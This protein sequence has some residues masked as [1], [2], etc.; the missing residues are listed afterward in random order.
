MKLFSKNTSKKTKRELFMRLAAVLVTGVILEVVAFLS[1]AWFASSGNVNATGMQVSVMDMGSYDLIID[2]TTYYENAEIYPYT[3]LFKSHLSTNEGY[4][5]VNSSSLSSGSIIAF[6]LYN[7][8]DENGKRHL[9][10]GSY[11]TLTFYL[12]THGNDVSIDFTFDI[13][14]Y[15]FTYVGEEI[16][17][18]GLS[19]VSDASVDNFFKGHFL[20][21]ESRTGTSGAY[22]YDDLIED[23]SFSI[24]TSTMSKSTTPGKTD[25]YEVTLYWNWPLTYE[26]IVD[27]MSTALVAKEYPI[28]LGNYLNEHPEYF[29]TRTPNGTETD[30]ELNDWYNDADQRIGERV[31]FILVSISGT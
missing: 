26:D 25:Y 24:D 15:Y 18:S 19:V 6:E 9:A 31:D 23:N 21:F 16:E 8:D 17:P 20:F 7:E 10:P 1:V 12:D 30:E 29:F 13:I 14:G 4:D 22:I 5:L 27:N 11:G 2:R 3:S 28:R